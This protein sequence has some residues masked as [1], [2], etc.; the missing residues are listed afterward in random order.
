MI[1]PSDLF[2]EREKDQS[3]EKV[4]KDNIFVELSP[5][6][7]LWRENA[8]NLWITGRT[9]SWTPFGC[10]TEANLEVIAA[11]TA[12]QVEGKCSQKATQVSKKANK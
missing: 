2:Q 12:G 6:P 11:W 5:T 9:R 1:F 8:G 4:Q 7:K 3:K 10:R